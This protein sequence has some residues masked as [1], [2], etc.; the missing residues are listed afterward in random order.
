MLPGADWNLSE[1]TVCTES[2]M[3]SAGLMRGSLEDPLR[4]SRRADK[5]RVADAQPLAAAI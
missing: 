2:T 1:K 5:R 4:Q 3:T